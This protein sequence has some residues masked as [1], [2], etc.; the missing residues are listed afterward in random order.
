MNYIKYI[1]SQSYRTKTDIQNRLSNLLEEK[2]RI[3]KLK[4]EL[5]NAQIIH[6]ILHK[7]LCR[8]SE[9]YRNLTE[10]DEQTSFFTTSH[11]EFQG[12]LEK[13][14]FLMSGHLQ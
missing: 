12:V 14:S 13:P 8:D 1:F 3:A 6:D 5:Q 7:D 9:V 10:V 4:A 11:G 2:E